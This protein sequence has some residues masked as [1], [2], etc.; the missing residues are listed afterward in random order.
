MVESP[1]KYKV[2][3]AHTWAASEERRILTETFMMNGMRWY[4]IDAKKCCIIDRCCSSQAFWFSSRS[5]S[6]YIIFLTFDPSCGNGKETVFIHRHV[7]FLHLAPQ[8][9]LDSRRRVPLSLQSNL[10][11]ASHRN[12][13]THPLTNLLVDALQFQEPKESQRFPMLLVQSPP[14]QSTTVTVIHLIK[15][16]RR[17]LHRAY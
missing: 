12:P 8:Y 3:T 16:P 6:L 5:S 1:A 7:Q 9:E 4:K 17:K 15:T 10:L 14:E 11:S 13:R 2:G